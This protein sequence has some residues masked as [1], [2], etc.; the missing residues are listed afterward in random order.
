VSAKPRL[1]L[2]AACGV[3]LEYM[4]VSARSLDVLPIADEL[5]RAASGGDVYVCDVKHDE[6]SWSNELTAHVIELKTADP[7]A[8]L[9]GLEEL[10]QQQ[11]ERIEQLLEPLG[12]RLMPSGMHPWMDPGRE[13]RLWPHDGE[14]IYQ[15][16]NRIFDCARHGWSNLQSVHLNLPFTGNDEFGRLHAAIRLLLPILPAV[17]ASSPFVGGQRTGW[18]DSRLGV[19]RSNSEK[20]PSIGGR[21]IPE[22]VF[23]VTDYDREILQPMYADIASQDPEGLLRHEFLNARGAI[24]RFERDTIE[25]R[26]LDVQECPLADLA[27]CALVTAV[28]Q[29]LVEEQW[30]S[31]VEQQSWPVEPLAELLFRV[32]CEGELAEIDDQKYLLAL[33]FAARGRC[34]AAQLW[35]ELIAMARARMGAEAERWREPWDLILEEGPLSRRILRRLPTSTVPPSRAQLREVYRDLC[36]CLVGGRLFS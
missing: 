18:L 31:T 36:G 8:T 26:V 11:I 2:F 24:A 17:A 35:R 1:H 3:E 14:A 19:Y 13:A 4:I 34:T 9:A 5:L 15:A 20:I 12:A 23:T 16:F 33:G 21:I 30:T 29:A 22:R 27:I 25:I 6:I 10:F 32:S 7:A 28:L